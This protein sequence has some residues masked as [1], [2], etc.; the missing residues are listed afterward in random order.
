MDNDKSK[1]GRFIFGCDRPITEVTRPAANET[2]P[3][4]VLTWIFFEEINSQLLD[5]GY[6]K[7]QII[8]VESIIKDTAGVECE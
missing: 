1:H 7:S 3:V 6:S 2:S 8:N 4:I 5:L